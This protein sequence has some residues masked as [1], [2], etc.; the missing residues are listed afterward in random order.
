MAGL[1][2]ET[3]I[4]S[5]MKTD[6]KGERFRPVTEDENRMLTEA[7]K[8][9]IRT[10]FAG[11]SDGHGSDHAE[12]VYRNAMMIA[13]T[14]PC[15]RQIVALAALLHDADDHKLFDTEDNAN[16][17]R[18]LSEHGVE[19]ESTERIVEVINAVSFSKNKGRKPETA[20]G[21]I[22]QDADRLDA[23]GAVGIARTFAYGGKNGRTL[24][25][26]IRHFHEKLLLL[27]DLVNTDQAKELAEQRHEWMLQFLQEWEEETGQ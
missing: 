6:D 7:A 25:D 11:N 9:Y 1:N 13:E 22:V 8:A 4:D 21:R 16:A 12:R 23:I 24:A 27:K 18:F 26:S 5:E 17:R 15:D 20:E 3:E 10:L 2:D 14:E 19:R